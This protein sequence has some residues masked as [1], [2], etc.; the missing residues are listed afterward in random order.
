MQSHFANSSSVRQIGAI[1]VRILGAGLGFLATV[2][3]THLLGAELAGVFFAS[4]AW[5]GFF[6]IL[7]RWGLQDIILLTIP[8]LAD[9]A[10]QSQLSARFMG[11]FGTVVVRIGAG[12][13][14]VAAIWAALLGVGVDLQLSFATIS[15]M[16]AITALLQLFSAYA[17]ARHAPVLAFAA[18]LA[19]P[20]LIVL[21][22][23][24]AL[25][26]SASK[27][28]VLEITGSYALAGL[29]CIALLASIFRRVINLTACGK[30]LP[31]RLK[32][33]ASTFAVTEL[34]LFITAFASVMIMPF[35]LSASETGTFNLALR[36]AAVATLVPTSIV[37]VITPV[38]VRSNGAKDVSV[39]RS[40]INQAR[41]VMAV[42]AVIYAFGVAALGPIVLDWAG[43]E[44]QAAKVPMLIMM[45]GFASGLLFGP[46]GVMLAI[47]GREGV[48]RKVAIW[49]AFLT[50]AG[51]MI[52]TLLFGLTGAASVVGA[53]FFLQRM[54]L[55]LAE[56][57]DVPGT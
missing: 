51:L 27:P 4:L 57:R 11:F 34:A 20:P 46:T 14:A 49:A 22:L 38:L 54:V 9:R 24:F 52:A 50:V 39:R 40:T 3:S 19:M 10:A 36:I 53:S 5:A 7:A 12:L 18:E 44:F 8:A 37:A 23:L 1:A 30:R 25:A 35:L 13:L 47:D 2:Y 15:S 21:L 45:V 6:S 17:K 32:R 16:F 26:S 48:A 29:I 33:R 55:F 56:Q 42:S 28:T 41:L 43:P 31:N